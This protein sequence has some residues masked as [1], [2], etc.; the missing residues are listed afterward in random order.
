MAPA[1]LRYAPADS[2]LL[3]EINAKLD[4]LLARL[5][6]GPRDQGDVALV[7]IIAAASR[8]LTFTSVALWRHREV[9]PALADALANADLESPR[10]LGKLLRRVE[11][12]DVG[13]V[14]ILCVGMHRDGKV[15]R[16]E[17]QE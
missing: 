10:M 6:P 16:A 3:R 8:G 13:G 2:Q 9:D 4:L 14:R 17:V 12:R 7:G 15:W 1:V 5:A 11:S